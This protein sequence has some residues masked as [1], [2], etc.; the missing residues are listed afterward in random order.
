M[1]TVFRSINV[2]QM[3]VIVWLDIGQNVIV[4]HSIKGMPTITKQNTVLGVEDGCIGISSPI[5]NLNTHKPR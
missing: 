4:G 1:D 5:Y 2:Y 3:E